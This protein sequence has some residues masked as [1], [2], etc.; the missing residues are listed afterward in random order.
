MSEAGF[1]GLEEGKGGWWVGASGKD[2]Q[3]YLSKNPTGSGK[4]KRL[5]HKGTAIALAVVDGV[6]YSSFGCQFRVFF[7][8]LDRFAGFREKIMFV[9]RGALNISGI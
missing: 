1:A 6:V 2:T 5:Q 3:K 4:T 8:F 9:V 7:V